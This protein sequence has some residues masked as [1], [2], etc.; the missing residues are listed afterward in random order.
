MSDRTTR[1]GRP[2]RIALFSVLLL[3]AAAAPSARAE[4]NHVFP[5]GGWHSYGDGWG[6]DRGTHYHRGQ[7]LPASAGTPLRAVFRGRVAYRQYQAGGAGYYVVIHGD[8]G[9]DSVYMHMQSPGF[10]APGES[11]RTGHLIGRVGSTGASTGPHLH[12]E[13]WTPHW[14]DGG[15]DF[16]PLSLLRKWDRPDP[17]QRVSANSGPERVSLDWSDSRDTDFEGY[18]VYRR[19]DGGSYTRIAT[20]K[21]SAFVDRSVR[22]GRTYHYRVRAFDQAGNT[23]SSSAHATG[24]PI[25]PYRQVVD[26]RDATRFE[27]STNWRTSSRSAA[28]RSSDYRFAPAATVPDAAR[29]RLRA[30]RDGQ[31]GIYIWQLSH[32]DY[33][34]SAPI[35]VRTPR[36]SDWR[37]LDLRSGGGRWVRLGIYTLRAGEEPEVL[38]SRRTSAQGWLIADAAQLVAR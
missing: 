8:D 36:G 19:P 12:F 38:V 21:S 31:Y 4:G 32:P 25:A 27:A 5:I 9:R 33:S 10:V 15:H 2:L 18:R 6:V 14:F 37:R 17:P 7:D 23:S 34:A 3:L 30:P 16:D 22:A 1:R 13:L 28:R 35:G 29:F 11:V 20:P 24:Q 26:N